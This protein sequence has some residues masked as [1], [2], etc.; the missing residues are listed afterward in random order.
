MNTSAPL[1]DLF[2]DPKNG[3]FL[4]RA[5][6]DTIREPLLVLDSDLRV[7]V[8][9]PSFYTAFKVLPS[10]TTG[11]LVYELGSGQWNIPE[12]RGLL[13]GVIPEHATVD[14]FEVVHDFPT[15]G[16]RTMLLSSR[17]IRYDNGQ[18][19]SLVTIY[20]ITD[21]REL[22]AQK[23]K[24]SRQKDLLLKEMRHRVANS[25]QL[26]ASILLIKAGIVESEDTR[27]HLEDAHERIMSI[28]TVQKQLDPTTLGE[29][30]AVK[31]YLEA[32][33]ASLARSMVGGRRPITIE[34]I[35]DAGTVSSEV[36]ISFGLLVTELIINSVKHA[37]PDNKKGHITVMYESR[38]TLWT[39]SVADDGVGSSRSD[40]IPR[41]GLGTSIVAALAGQLQA[42]TQSE[43]GPDGTK[44][45]FTHTAPE[46]GLISTR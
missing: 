43:S 11:K 27:K 2:N 6:I 42:Q 38:G 20:D 32:L 12:L 25:L 37:F 41:H 18:K 4:T 16:K 31:P 36:A 35:A 21:R 13:K 28:A 19:K 24:L 22:E 40:G 26:I 14:A 44:V 17:E 34:V 3:H 9:S 45:Q 15:I 30:I 39:L 23:E 10:D 8:A 5:I 46:I 1:E 29:D 33:A 7:L